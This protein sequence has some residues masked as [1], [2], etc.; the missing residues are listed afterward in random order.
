[1][2]TGIFGMSCLAINWRL[3]EAGLS[4]PEPGGDRAE[5]LLGVRFGP[6][7]NQCDC[8]ADFLP[9]K[10]GQVDQPV[11]CLYGIGVEL[12]E[13]FSFWRCRQT[14]VCKEVEQFGKVVRAAKSDSGRRQ[15]RLECFFDSLLRVKTDDG[16][17]DVTNGT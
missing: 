1:M 8:L 16:V 10:A 15:N 3:K 5:R 6:G 4:Y 2:N 17:T 14:R 13:G 12:I 11:A 9:I 7:Q